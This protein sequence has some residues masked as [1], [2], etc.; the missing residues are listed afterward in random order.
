M[1]ETL[2][3]VFHAES[4]N[5]F[6]FHIENQSFMNQPTKKNITIIVTIHNTRVAIF[7]KI[8]LLKL[9][10]INFKSGKV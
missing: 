4:P 1:K 10:S 7:M 8:Y 5:K 6:Y 3:A 9:T 2:E